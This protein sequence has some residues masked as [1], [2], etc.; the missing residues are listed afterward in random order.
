VVASL[1][2]HL[3]VGGL[4]R[5]VDAQLLVLERQIGVEALALRDQRSLELHPLVALPLIER[6][7]ALHMLSANLFALLGQ[8]LVLL[9]PLLNL[10]G[11]TRRA[12][13]FFFS[14]V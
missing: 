9:L 11:R 14:F 13:V 3:G 1:G 12:T 4:E 7:L 6:D 2:V 8:G 5:G 10:S